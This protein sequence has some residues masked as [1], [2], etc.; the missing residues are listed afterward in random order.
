MTDYRRANFPGGYYYFTVVTHDRRAIFADPL[1][2]ECLHIAWD[3]TRRQ[4]PR[5]GFS[6]VLA[7]RLAWF[8]FCRKTDIPLS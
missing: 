8:S 7:N 3:Q 2:R 4:M 1:A 5:R 6:S